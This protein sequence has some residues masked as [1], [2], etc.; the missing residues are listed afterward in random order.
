[1]VSDSERRLREAV[2]GAAARGTRNIDL[3]ALVEALDQQEELLGSVLRRRLTDALGHME[4]RDAWSVRTM[5]DGHVYRLGDRGYAGAFI[6]LVRHGTWRGKPVDSGVTPVVTTA[7][8]TSLLDFYREPAVQTA[9]CV[10]L[11]KQLTGHA[12]L[13]E[14]VQQEVADTV[15]FAAREVRDL[16]GDDV[17]RTVA[18]DR[19]TDTVSSFFASA[20]GHQALTLVGKAMATG[21]GK[22]VLAKMSMALAHAAATGALQSGV[23]AVVKKVGVTALL[24][25]TVGKAALAL[26]F[27]GAAVPVEAITAAVVAVLIPYQWKKLPEKLA[28]TIP[29]QILPALS[30]GWSNVHSSVVPVLVRQ[31]A[32]EA[33][34]D[35]ART[36]IPSAP[37]SHGRTRVLSIVEP[38]AFR[39]FRQHA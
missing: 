8:E 30:G 27:G 15:S 38:E 20:A 1:M 25:T 14:A 4:P 29:D 35:V 26:V 37:P 24:K 13:G 11:D 12:V 23:V 32:T 28:R 19:V 34:W 33:L 17:A 5:P 9:L 10:E 16:L 22:A 18:L 36:L 21:A 31:L 3:N 39:R 7:I 6:A 2:E